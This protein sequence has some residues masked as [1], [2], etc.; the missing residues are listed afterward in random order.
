MSSDSIVID[1]AYFYVDDL[2]DRH[3]G[4]LKNMWRC[5]IDMTMPNTFINAAETCSPK[6]MH[7]ETIFS[8]PAPWS[9]GINIDRKKA[10]YGC[11]FEAVERYCSTF[12]PKEL[13][14][15]A[16]ENE[17]VKRGLECMSSDQFDYFT[18]EQY[19][20][21]EKMGKEAPY[22][23]WLPDSPIQWVESHALSDDRSF[24]MPAQLMYC[25]CELAKNEP[26]LFDPFST[27]MAAHRTL[28]KAIYL[29]LCEVIER[30]SLVIFWHNM[31]PS[32]IIREDSLIGI[33]SEI[34]SLLERLKSVPG[35]EL[36]VKDITS[37]SQIPTLLCVIRNRWNPEATATAF[38]AA[39]DLNPII[40]LRKSMN[41]CSGKYTL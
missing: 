14:H 28:D 22:Q 4:F 9:C 7:P 1:P 13:L 8:H 10:K 38:A 17:M 24:F 15:F 3:V 34:D 31:L 23:R 25:P 6:E 39:T 18:E 20:M 11:I 29:G 26:R 32:P 30:D 35:L 41:E 2:V 37:D 40:A 27:G 19:A 36:L 5:R 33:D 12:V 16:S 21:L